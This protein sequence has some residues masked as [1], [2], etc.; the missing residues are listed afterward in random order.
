[1]P[2]AWINGLGHDA[3]GNSYFSTS[4]IHRVYKVDAIT[5]EVSVFAG[6]A[7]SGFGGDGGPATAAALTS[8]RDIDFDAAGNA[9]IS[10]GGR[11]IRR[12]DAVTGIIT[13]FA[14]NSNSG[15]TGDGGPAIA[16]SFLGLGTMTFDA[17]GNLVLK[18]GCAF[19]RIDAT[20]G[21]ITRI[22]GSAGCAPL[23]TGEGGSALAARF[24]QFPSWA[25]APSGDIFLAWG[26]TYD[27]SAPP[28][29]SS[30]RSRHLRA[31]SGQPEGPRLRYPS[32][33]AFDAE[34]RLYW[35]TPFPGH[36]IRI[37]GLVDTTPP[38]IFLNVV[39]TE[40][41]NGWYRSNVTVSWSMRELE[42]GSSQVVTSGCTQSYVTSDTPGVTFTC[43]ATSPGGTNSRSV[44][45]KRD[46]VMPQLA[47]GAPTPT[48]DASGWNYTDVSVPFDASDELSG[49]Y[50]TNSG[51]PVIVTGEGQ[52]LTAEVVVTDQA[53]NTATF[54]TP[55]FRIDRSPR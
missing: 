20:T 33:M 26:E 40:G 22:A 41:V 3:A 34:G 39:G 52:G 7:N 24:P 2:N 35:S 55:Q 46:T 37:S 12:V 19:R 29:A 30:P 25:M 9:Y 21:I 42:S 4:F 23:Y 31:D 13:T 15:S 53:G 28:P 32:A 14:G 43:T 50:T 10:D 54:T 17:A 1:M 27:G 36:I 44:T 8:P 16:A 18:D 5:G 6:Q 51:N 38:E 47:F 11:R 49:V 45:I 48:P